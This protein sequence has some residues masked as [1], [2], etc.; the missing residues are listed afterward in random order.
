MNPCGRGLPENGVVDRHEQQLRVAAGLLPQ[1]P[2][3]AMAVSNALR[4]R[5]TSETSATVLG[6]FCVL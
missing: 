5:R 3:A 2:A 1:S 6:G 4:C